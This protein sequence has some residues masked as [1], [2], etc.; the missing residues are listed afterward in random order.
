MDFKQS[1][2]YTCIQNRRNTNESV[3]RIEITS[4]GFQVYY[5]RLVCRLRIINT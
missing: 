1:Y 3:I 5:I 2:T 4:F